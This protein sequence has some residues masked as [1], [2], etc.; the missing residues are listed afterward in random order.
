MHKQPLLILCLCFILGIL[1]QDYVLVSLQVVYILLVFSFL[2]L[3]LYLIKDFYFHRIRHV[4][5]FI[6]FFSLGVFAHFLNSRKPELPELESR[7]NIVFKIN[8]KLNSNEKNRRYE[9]TAWKG[10]ESF[11]SVLSVPK[12]DAELDFLHYYKAEAYI[13]PLQKPYSDF[14]FDYGKYLSRKDIYFQAYLPNS[15][16]TGARTDLT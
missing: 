8:K 4:S 5:L 1:L 10:S 9:I 14:Q 12:S 15:F 6:L 11:L 2:S 13:N 16:Q 3:S 7:E